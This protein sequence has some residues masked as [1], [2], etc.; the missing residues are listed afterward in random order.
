MYKKGGF[1]GRRVGRKTTKGGMRG[2]AKVYAPKKA[3]NV[4][5]LQSQVKGLIRKQKREVEMKRQF[6]AS[7]A[8]SNVGQVN[9]NGSGV[10]CLDITSCM[11]IGAAA[12]VQDRVGNKVNLKGI[13]LRYQ[14][15]Q[16]SALA[17]GVKYIMEVYKTTD[18]STSIGSLPGTL[19]NSDT[20]SGVIDYNSTRAMLYRNIY[21]R[22]YAKS[23]YI[24]A[25]STSSVANFVDKKVLIKQR[26]ML[27]WPTAATTNPQNIRYFVIIRAS[28]G[29][30]N[31]S[32]ASTLTN[33]PLT[34][35]NTGALCNLYATSY[36][37]D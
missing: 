36:F 22:I 24:P 14:L 37:T 31:T 25:D 9:A 33:I 10:L 15:Q 12:G 2:A 21:K 23:I 16:Q 28:A 18:L 11:S 7:P 29:N 1:R 3:I 27:E 6:M 17:I 34:A 26:Q 19:Y 32:T 35:V 20:I 30:L 8:T 13:F 5:K 4:S